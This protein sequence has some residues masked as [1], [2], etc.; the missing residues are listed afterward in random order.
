MTVFTPRSQ[1]VRDQPTSPLFSQL[2]LAGVVKVTHEGRL[3]VR[4]RIYL[5]VWPFCGLVLRGRIPRR[6]YPSDPKTLG[7]HV[8]RTRMDRRLLRVHVARELAVSVGTVKNW[9]KNRTTVAARLLPRVV[10]FL[11]YDPT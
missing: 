6:G 11:G 1:A 5:P 8:H 10:A 2:K 3:V 7:E 4:N 9:E